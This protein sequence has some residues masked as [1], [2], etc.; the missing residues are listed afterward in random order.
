MLAD[1]LYDNDK[2][3]SYNLVPLNIGY[4]VSYA[5]KYYKDE[6]DFKLYRNI[7][8]FIKDF[9][10]DP[11]SVVAFSQ[12]IWN[13]DL[14]KGILRWIKSKYPNILSISGGP[15]IGISEESIGIF[16]K[17]NPSVDLCV[18]GYGEYG[19]AQIL[20]IYIET[21]GNI[22]LIKSNPI[23][24]VAFLLNGKLVNTESEQLLVKPNISMEKE[25]PS[26]YL[27]GLFDEFLRD[28]YSPIVQGMR[29]CPFKCTFCFA[30][31]L[32]IAK[33][34]EKHVLDEIN[35]IYKKTKSSALVFTDDNFGMYRRDKNIAKK[36]RELYDK[37][38]IP[39]KIYMYYSKKPTETV[40][41]T[42][43]IMGD[44]TPF[45]ISYQSRNEKTLDA[46]ERYN[47]EDENTK[48]IIKTCKENSVPVT[49]EMIFGLPYETK[50]S[51]MAG[52][53]E[54][55]SLDV[56]TIAIYHAKYFNG[57]ELSTKNSREESGMVT[58]HRFYED[59]FQLIKTNTSYGDILACETDEV[60]VSSSSYSLDDF[61]EIRML[62]FWI[63]LFF[64]K[65]IY[66]DVLKHIEIFGISPFDFI[67]RL[68]DGKR[69]PNSIELFFDE[70][71]EK[72]KGELF[73]T[74]VDLK[75]AYRDIVKNNPGYKS[76][77]INLYYSYALIYTDIRNDLDF[78]MKKTLQDMGKKVL[79]KSKYN[80][81]NEP[82]SEL[83]K[84]NSFKILDIDFFNKKVKRYSKNNNLSFDG[85]LDL[86]QGSD[87]SQRYLLEGTKSS[88]IENDV[89][90]NNEL[91][92]NRTAKFNYNFLAW[93]ASGYKKQIN[94]FKSPNAIDF[95]FN[96]VNSKQY[97]V[98]VK[99]VDED[100]RAYVWHN[101][102]T[103]SNVILDSKI[104]KNRR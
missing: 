84:Y 78:F 54:L 81:F 7:D 43:K 40:M 5:N 99:Q 24:G 75:N 3:P 97:E 19:F 79:S 100:M 25:I 77:K 71:K 59:N 48:L 46:I 22:E 62:G 89:S 90:F 34:S 36:I 58:M 56:D 47:L 57:T 31:K 92:V 74:H 91:L 85:T 28:G 69:A 93:K 61:L 102:I 86:N 50:D 88:K 66:Y 72:Y 65:K 73:E 60:P 83:F 4:L 23:N 27:T 49:S 53:E 41:E 87:N 8:K 67:Q 70:V 32:K 44:L 33:F 15:M 21:K 76:I 12:Y 45:F 101:Y 80:N 9:N 6:F 95:K 82:L 52:V 39:S 13:D 11:P 37:N 96:P 1:F 30:S 2:G 42:S 10:D 51:F 64:A 18:P 98:F 26:P 103:S 94:K 55:Y 68:I 17:E 63:E 104:I 29:G 35:Y 38:G 20:N 16:F 14:T